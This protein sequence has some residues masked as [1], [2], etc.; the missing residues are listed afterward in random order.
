MNDDRSTAR[1]VFPKPP[2]SKPP[3]LDVAAVRSKTGLS[4]TEFGRKFILDPGTL[5]SWEQGIREPE[6]PARLLL[7]V[8]DE[9]A[10]VVG[11]VADQLR[12]E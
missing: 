7:A 1:I 12:S 8:I 2:S 6:G 3:K 9:A 5:R 10:D 4:Q 11:R